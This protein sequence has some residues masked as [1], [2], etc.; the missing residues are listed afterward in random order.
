[1]ITMAFTSYYSNVKYLFLGSL[2]ILVSVA[3]FFLSSLPNVRRSPGYAA[4]STTPL[5]FFW[6]FLGI[7]ILLLVIGVWTKLR[8]KKKVL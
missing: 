1:M 2:S 4:P 6:L 8:T 7:G 5:F 3:S